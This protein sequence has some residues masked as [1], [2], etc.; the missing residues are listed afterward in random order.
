MI[1]A[2]HLEDTHIAISD[3]DDAGILARTLDDDPALG[4]K[5][6]QMHAGGFVGAMFAPHH[7]EDAELD[8]IGL[9]IQKPLDARIFVFVEPMLANSLW[10]DGSHGPP[11]PRSARHL[12][13]KRGRKTPARGFFLPRL[14]GRWPESPPGGTGMRKCKF[15]TAYRP[16]RRTVRAHPVGAPADRRRIPD[17]ASAPA[18]CVFHSECRRCHVRSRLDVR[19]GHSGTRPALLL[20]SGRA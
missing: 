15:P 19:R 11:L 18:R 6:A 8:E 13:R 7:R 14:R 12:P 9:A 4:R 20:P 1:V 3:I 5:L 16:V 17:A 2:L 10:R